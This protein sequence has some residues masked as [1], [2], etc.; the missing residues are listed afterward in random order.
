MLAD[1]RAPVRLFHAARCILEGTMSFSSAT[2]APRIDRVTAPQM[3]PSVARS[4]FELANPQAP[5]S[6]PPNADV[7]AI[8]VS[9]GAGVR[10]PAMRGLH[11]PTARLPER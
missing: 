6:E 11:R 7:S 5:A 4:S 1:W 9:E 3:R 10:A 8:G 2:R